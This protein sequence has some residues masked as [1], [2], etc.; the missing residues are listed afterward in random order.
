ML[1]NF[2]LITALLSLLSCVET[3]TRL[4]RA[5]TLAGDNRGE[6]E[7]VLEHYKGDSLKY[8][9][10]CFLIENMPYHHGYEDA[11]LD[12]V[13]AVL[14]TAPQGGGYI[15]E[16]GRKRKWQLFS[17]RTLPVSQDVRRM[18]AEL[19]IENIDHAF[20]A[21]GRAPWAGHYS[22]DDFCEWILPYRVG[23][24]PLESWRPAY[25]AH[26]RPILDSLYQGDDIL[27]AA[28][29]L[30]KFLKYETPF[31]PNSEFDLPHLGP[32]YLLKYRL[33][34][35]RETTDHTVYIYRALGFPVGIDGYLYSPSNRHSHVWNILKHT[36]GSTLPFWYMDSRDLTVGMTDGRKKG[37]VYR[38]CYGAQAEKHPGICRDGSAPPAVR[39]P[40]RKDVTAEYSGS[41][42]YTIGVD[43]NAAGRFVALGIFTPSGYVPVD[44]ALRRG[45]RAVAE[46]IEPGV[47][48]QPLCGEEGAFNPC[49]YPFMVQDGEVRTFVP[50]RDKVVS[51]P[52]RRKY[53]L[54]N[55][56]VEYMSWMTGARI[57]GSNDMEFRSRET[58]CRIADTPRVNVNFYPSSPSRP[59]RYVRFVP[60]RGWRAEVA[61]LAFY[62][63]FRD[64][65]P[66]PAK[67]VS[68]CP[69]VDG[70]PA[71]AMDKANDNDWLTFF[72]SEKADGTVTFDLQHPAWI[73]KIL[74]VPR[75]DDN[76][77]TPG[78]VYELFY[79]NGTAGWESLGRQTASG[80]ELTYGNIPDG[81]LL[82]LRNLTRGR[83]E[84]VF[85]LDGGKQRFVGYE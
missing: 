62:E 6:L 27:E 68:G 39:N 14:A 44:V 7:K 31:S 47:I 76:F 64:D 67:A 59:Y 4:E 25:Y 78:N 77:I 66:V 52:L 70:N 41:N 74:F 38:T 10:A 13:K 3:E 40:L 57:E 20:E 85:Y 61:E 81:A 50:D 37:K 33:G 54:Q 42:R 29:A 30:N 73:R 84:Q 83:E 18:T 24:E 58:L 69:P 53:P 19:L 2:L 1:R 23:D 21:W 17:Y 12:S 9:A 51:A 75:N 35:C 72:F 32:G 80:Y 49:G 63:D 46:D 15:P 45:D 60:R 55:H 5:L 34:T 48:Y 82:W 26:Y 65:D 11:R 71:H 22:F 79:Q 56:I 16:S 36:D 8:S 28:D 43:R